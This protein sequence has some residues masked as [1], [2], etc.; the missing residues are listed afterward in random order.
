MTS[1]GSH[2]KCGSVVIA[3]KYRVLCFLPVEVYIHDF[4]PGESFCNGNIMEKPTT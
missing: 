3:S 4:F 1:L 2:N